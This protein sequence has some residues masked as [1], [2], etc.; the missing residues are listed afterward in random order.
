MKSAVDTM[1]RDNIKRI[2]KEKGI[3]RCKVASDL[4]M[5]NAEF[6]RMIAGRRI[7]RACYIPTIATALGVTPN[8]LFEGTNK[9]G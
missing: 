1:L 7:L 6:S 3:K 2:F 5:D 8:E 9:A 4:G